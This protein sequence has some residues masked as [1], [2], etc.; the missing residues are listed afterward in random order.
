MLVKFSF[1]F[2]LWFG[3]RADEFSVIDR[4][5]LGELLRG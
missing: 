2:F 5:Y 1:S 4:S 3:L